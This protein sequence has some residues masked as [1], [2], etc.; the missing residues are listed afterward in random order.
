AIP[1]VPSLT[2]DHYSVVVYDGAVADALSDEKLV[3]VDQL[4]ISVARNG[5]LSN[6]DERVVRRFFD[7]GGKVWLSASG[8]Q[9]NSE[10][11]RRVFSAD[12]AIG[13]DGPSR[14]DTVTAVSAD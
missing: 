5:T 4:W 3:E 14:L 8:G 6:A 10:S 12:R 11:F 13:G 9:A 7:R 2:K 1:A